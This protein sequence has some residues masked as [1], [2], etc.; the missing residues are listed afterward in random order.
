MSDGR[1]PAEKCP[2]CERYM[3]LRGYELRRAVA[4]FR[5]LVCAADDHEAVV[6]IRFGKGKDDAPTIATNDTLPGV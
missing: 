6:R 4:W 2:V 3:T 1:S 5:V